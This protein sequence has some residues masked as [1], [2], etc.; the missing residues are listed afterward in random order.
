MRRY[1]KSLF[2]LGT[3]VLL[4]ASALAGCKSA[5]GQTEPPA[6]A[7]DST[8]QET[9]KAEAVQ[10]KLMN[11]WAGA[12]SKAGEFANMV[13]A[14]N[15]AYKGQY[16][17]VVED[18]TDY[19][20]YTDKVRILVSTGSTPD[21]FTFVKTSNLELYSESGNLMDL[22]ELLEEP[23]MAE[24]FMPGVVDSAKYEGK[25]Y[26]MPYENALIPIMFNNRL[27]EN[28][29]IKAVPE[30][31]EALFEDCEKLKASGIAPLT[32]MTN[33][34][35]WT[36]MLWYTY[37]LAACGGPDVYERGLDDSAFVEAAEL[38]L[39]MFDYTTSDAVGADASVVNGHFFNE[40]AAVYPNGSWIFG[41]IKS[42]GVEGLYD[43]IILSPGFSY[44]GNN[45]GAYVNSIQAY[46][47]A[48]KQEDP[49]KEEA[50]KAFFRFITEPDRVT[51][52]SN[53]SGSLFVIKTTVDENTDPLQAELVAQA[54]KA[55]FLLETFESKMPAAVANGFA[56]A[57]E[58]MVLGETTPEEFVQTLKTLS[59]E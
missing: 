10:L 36:S 51:K 33:D 17:I 57:L 58:S 28:A 24:R 32:Q 21:L 26:C 34:V 39:K 9:V 54:D 20:A 43:N 4:A 15:E 47:A 3:A 12:D 31:Y 22:T 6:S 13:N 55:D 59:E 40:R 23:E 44:K 25:N 14:F 35:A 42:E 56:P 11:I 30:S 7:G 46:F 53:E 29:G 2:A 16:E 45:G 37:A 50:V 48:A 49:K 52:L 1:K 19:D 8:S 5:G 18:Q 38:L 27:L 41:R